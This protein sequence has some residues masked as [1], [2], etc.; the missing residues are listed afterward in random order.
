MKFDGIR[1]LDLTQFLPGPTV[2]LM[3]ADHGADVIKIESVQAGEPTRTIGQRRPGQDQTVYFQ[4]TQRGKRSLTLNLKDD[5]AKQIFT[6]LAATADVVIESFRPGVA[7][8]L[9]VDYEAVRAVKPDIV[10]AS[11]SAF[12]QTGPMNQDPAHDLAVQAYCGL[13]SCN[14]DANGEPVIPAMPAADMLVAAQTLAGISM[15]LFRRASTGE[16]DYLDMS[17]M[18]AVLSSMPN[19][20]GAAFGEQ[21]APTLNH[22]RI[23]GGA[24]LYKIYATSDG[25]HIALGGSEIKFATNLLNHLGRPDLIER[26]KAPP[27]PEQFP[28]MEFLETTF[29]TKT[30]AEWVSELADVDLCFAPVNDLRTGLNLPQ[31]SHRNMVIHDEQGH[32]HLGVAIQFQS[33]PGT[34]NFSAPDLGEHNQTILA[35]L[36]YTADEVANLRSNGTI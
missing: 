23:W 12:G 2:T 27:G 21:R 17:M 14:A 4:N 18:D 16:G 35:E 6:R 28:V 25:K 19:S 13:L 26:C 8:R 15:A 34:V 11:I 30:Q 10:Y 9:G 31:N 3:M 29:K 33:E 22:E 1:V 32:E 36:G 7:K 5:S 20:M 24:A